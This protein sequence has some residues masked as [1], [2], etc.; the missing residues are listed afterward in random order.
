LMIR[1]LT[2]IK[3]PLAVLHSITPLTRTSEL[4]WLICHNSRRLSNW[5][6]QSPVISFTKLL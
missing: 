6:D 1:L 2:L 4:S 5:V 3:R